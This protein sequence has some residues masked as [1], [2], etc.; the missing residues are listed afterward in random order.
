M[1]SNSDLQALILARAGECITF[2]S[3]NE[4]GYGIVESFRGIVKEVIKE[5]HDLPLVRDMDARLVTNVLYREF[6]S[7]AL[8]ITDAYLKGKR[9]DD[10]YQSMFGGYN[11]LNNV[12]VVSTKMLEVDEI[13]STEDYDRFIDRTLKVCLHEVG[14]KFGLTDHG[15]RKTDYDG[16]LCPMSRQ[17]SDR[18]G[19]KGYVLAI[20]DSRGEKFCDEC[21]EFLNYWYKS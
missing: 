14:H 12:A 15:E 5:H 8:G 17:D 21:M 2:S 3:L 1:H 6:G 11:P 7:H 18:Y 19:N 4:I 13:V 16:S 9:K 10:F 20:I